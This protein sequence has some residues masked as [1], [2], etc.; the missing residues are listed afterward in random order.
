MIGA[1]IPPQHVFVLVAEIR[2]VPA[3]VVV[4]GDEEA[5]VIQG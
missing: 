3:V 4:G 5:V 2:L 1:R